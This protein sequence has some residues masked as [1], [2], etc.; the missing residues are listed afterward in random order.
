MAVHI[1]SC[2]ILQTICHYMGPIYPSVEGKDRQILWIRDAK[3][4]ACH[5]SLLEGFCS[6][7]DPLQLLRDPFCGIAG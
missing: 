4:Q 6:A 2:R 1:C 7:L 5:L 3:V